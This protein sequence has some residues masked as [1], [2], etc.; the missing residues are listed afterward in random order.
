MRNLTANVDYK[1]WHTSYVKKVFCL[2]SLRISS[3]KR[4]KMAIVLK[5][6]RRYVSF[7]SQNAIYDRIFQTK[8]YYIEE[9]MT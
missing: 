6:F 9:I 7:C 5:I 4:R 2:N 1:R 3:L 8:E